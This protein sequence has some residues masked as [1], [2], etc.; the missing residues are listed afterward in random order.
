MGSMDSVDNL[1]ATATAA[2]PWIPHSRPESQENFQSCKI[3][4]E[5]DPTGLGSSS[6]GLDFDVGHILRPSGL[7]RGGDMWHI[8]GARGG[9]MW[10]IL[11]GTRR[12]AAKS[13]LVGLLGCPWGSPGPPPKTI[14]NLRFLRGWRLKLSTVAQ[15]LTIC[16]RPQG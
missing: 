12:G 14:K 5:I 1:L 13:P 6:L 3:E 2:D 15:I 10:H 11:G 4:I 7:W 16:L 8:L 9:D